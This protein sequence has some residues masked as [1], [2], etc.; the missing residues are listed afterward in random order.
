MLNATGALVDTCWGGSPAEAASAQAD[1][2]P[3]ATSRARADV[4]QLISALREHRL[5]TD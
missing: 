2:H 5:L 4:D 1:A 3:A